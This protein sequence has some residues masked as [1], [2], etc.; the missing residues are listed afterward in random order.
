MTD[1]ATHGTVSVAILAHQMR[2]PER[3]PGDEPDQQVPSRGP[4]P[5]TA[6]RHPEQTH[7]DER[8]GPP[9][10]VRERGP[11]AGPGRDGREQAQRS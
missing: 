10:D 5:L 2:E 3:H 1:S 8:G 11:Q 4:R 7:A 9:R 6:Q